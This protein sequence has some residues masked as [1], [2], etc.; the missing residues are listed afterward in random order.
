MTQIQEYQ[1]YLAAVDA[2]KR[3]RAFAKDI[4]D[5]GHTV[6]SVRVQIIT[7]APDGKRSSSKF[8][9]DGVELVIG[10]DF[11]SVS[12]KAI[13][14]LRDKANAAGV[15]AKAALDAASDDIISE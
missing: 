7:E 9:N 12:N 1:D 11:A 15:I 10:E 5:N 14:A 6:R 13:R 2:K 4:T 8:F 3:A